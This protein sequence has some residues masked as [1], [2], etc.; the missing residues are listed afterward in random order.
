MMLTS[1]CKSFIRWVSIALVSLF[2]YLLV[3]GVGA[4]SFDK[5]IMYF[6]EKII[7]V[8]YHRASLEIMQEHTN[9]V[10]LAAFIA[11]PICVALILI[12]FKKVR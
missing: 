7:S 3:G 11:F 2:Y 8:E 6:S 4:I 1:K 9:S 5:D 12:I 10:Y